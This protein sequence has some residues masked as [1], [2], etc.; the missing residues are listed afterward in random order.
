M[1]LRKKSA[2]KKHRQS[3]KRRERNRFV[4]STL[5]TKMKRYAEALQSEDVEKSGAFLRELVSL[6]D[7]AAAKGVIHRNKASR[8]VSRFSAKL[9]ELRRS[10]GGT[11]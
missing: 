7:K 2:Q 5:K 1:G 3:L 10:G 6:A 11:A 8:Y 9:S 4:L